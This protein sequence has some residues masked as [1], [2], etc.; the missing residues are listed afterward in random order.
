[1]EYRYPHFRRELVLEDL[2]FRGGPWPGQP[3]PDFDL[4]TAGGGRVRKHD[5]VG[6]PLLL[7][8]GSVT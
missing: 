1:M 6:R 4:P 8:F 2:A 7:L 3:L 5:F